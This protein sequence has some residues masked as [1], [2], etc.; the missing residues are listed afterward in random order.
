MVYEA[1]L[2]LALLS[3]ILSGVIYLVIHS[4]VTGNSF[5]IGNLFIVFNTTTYKK[6][7]CNTICRCTVF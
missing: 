4:F 1:A 2:I 3:V 6:M 7:I 5:V